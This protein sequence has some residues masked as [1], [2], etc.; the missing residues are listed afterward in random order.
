MGSSQSAPQ[1]ADAGIAPPISSSLPPELLREIRW[2]EKD[3]FHLLGRV[4]MEVFRTKELPLYKRVWEQRQQ[5]QALR[6]SQIPYQAGYGFVVGIV[7]AGV[8][9]F[10]RGLRLANWRLSG[11]I[12]RVQRGTAST[13]G[14]FA[15]FMGL[16]Y[17]FE[18]VLYKYVTG[19]HGKE[20]TVAA[21]FCT[22]ALIAL[23]QGRASALYQ[24]AL[25][26]GMMFV[27][28]SC[29]EWLGKKTNQILAEE[30]GREQA[31]QA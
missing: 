8:S 17:F 25:G 7:I 31:Q 3:N 1:V 24:G 9:D 21:A 11:G 26:A 12:G 30:L 14:N 6:F 23:P 16:L 2:K 13:A 15:A 10:W 27:L 19:R 5:S 22:S 28:I 4:R 20:E 29:S 18:T